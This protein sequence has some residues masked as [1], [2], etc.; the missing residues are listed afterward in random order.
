MRAS[1]DRRDLPC[2]APARRGGLPRNDGG[3]CGNRPHLRR[4]WRAHDS[5][6]CGHLGRGQCLRTGGRCHPRHGADEPGPPGESG[7]S[8]RHR[9]GRSHAQAAQHPSARYRAVLP[10]RSGGGRDARRHDRDAGVRHQRGALRHAQGECA[11]AHGG[12]ARWADHQ[13]RWARAQVGGGLRP[14]PALCRLRGNARC[15]DRDY[16]QALRYPR[17]DLGG[18]MLLPPRSR[19]RSTR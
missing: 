12:A 10:H 4:A 7:G 13:D 9:P 2:A 8:R 11:G 15:D 16:A 14:D 5:L 1:R 3:S 19:P 6:W 18:G 17:G